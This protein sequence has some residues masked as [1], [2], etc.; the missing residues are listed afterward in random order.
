MS[1]WVLTC[2]T[3]YYRPSEVFSLKVGDLLRPASCHPHFALQL[4]PSEQG[5]EPSK[6]RV[7]DDGVPLDSPILPWLPLALPKHL[8]LRQ[9]ASTE[10]M[11]SFRYSAL[12]AK[13]RKACAELGIRDASQNRLRHGG[14]SH[15]AA[16][17][18]RTLAEIKRRGRWT[19]DTRCPPVREADLAAERRLQGFTDA[20][21]ES[22]GCGGKLA[23]AIRRLEGRKIPQT[24][25]GGFIVEVF[26]GS[27]RLS[28]ASVA[29]DI[30]AVVFDV[31]EGPS[32]DLLQPA[33]RRRLCR[34]IRHEK[35]LG[36]W[37]GFPCGTF[38]R[39]R[40]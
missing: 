13:F 17:R 25:R 26:S 27:G 3:T 22:A 10:D 23:R 6:T 16:A 40:K 21:V 15:D 33:I 35:C 36:V 28:L 18:L 5:G 9:R 11:F 32:G 34:L 31:V 38:S 1:L 29:V 20:G 39:A 24:L 4:H 19:S 2:F 7:F 37:F 8:K 14:A 12:F 30:R